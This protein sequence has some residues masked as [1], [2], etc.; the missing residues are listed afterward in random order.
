M[1]ARRRQRDRASPA[2]RQRLGHMPRRSG[3]RFPGATGKPTP[4]GPITSVKDRLKSFS[5][6]QPPSRR[7]AKNKRQTPSVGGGGSGLAT[8]HLNKTE[9]ESVLGS[10][11]KKHRSPRG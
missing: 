5:A 4:S 1:R 7:K 6:I 9:S 3:G 2:I 10:R 11:S 8:P